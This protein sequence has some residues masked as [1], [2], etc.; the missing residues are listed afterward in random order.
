[1]SLNR[2][3]RVTSTG[4]N[5]KEQSRKQS[6]KFGWRHIPQEEIAA[7]MYSSGE[8]DRIGI[9][10]I[11]FL[12]DYVRGNQLRKVVHGEFREY[13]LVDVLHLFCVE[14]DK[15]KGIFELAEGSF[16]SPAS[17]I[18]EFEFRGREGVSR[19]IGNDSFKGILRESETDDT[20]RKLIERKWIVLAVCDGKVIEGHMRWKPPIT[21]RIG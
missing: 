3:T 16:N 18:E 19:Q 4:A 1:M 14:M 20:K 12:D 7:N 6:F 11:A 15:A 10:R 9:L 5:R 17:G 21:I 8:V 13:F 2:L